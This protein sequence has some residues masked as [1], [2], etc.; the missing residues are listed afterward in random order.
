LSKEE[1]FGQMSQMY[2]VNIRPDLLEKFT[3]EQVKSLGRELISYLNLQ[4][5]KVEI[6]EQVGKKIETRV[7]DVERLQ[8]VNQDANLCSF[9]NLI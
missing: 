3:S 6:Q 2:E 1:R 5:A 9:M 4:K 8:P 7:I